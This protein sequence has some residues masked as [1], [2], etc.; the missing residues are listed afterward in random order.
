MPAHSALHPRLAKS[1]MQPGVS[2][3]FELQ[4]ATLLMLSSEKKRRIV[5][6]RVDLQG[7]HW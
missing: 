7:S 6:E 5:D 1:A 2:A 4:D 3:Q